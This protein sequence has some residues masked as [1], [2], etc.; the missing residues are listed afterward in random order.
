MTSG[1]IERGR[2]EHR[3]R[4]VSQEDSTAHLVAARHDPHRFGAFYRLEHRSL[5]R[6]VHRQV[7]CAELAADLTAE[8]FA[9]ALQWLR[10]FDPERGSAR[11]WL[12]G[13][14]RNEVRMWARKGRVSQSARQRLGITTPAFTETDEAMIDARH[15]ANGLL[16]QSRE[17]FEALGDLDRQVVQMRVIDELP[18]AVI[19]T[20]LD[21]SEV[22]ARVR[23]SRA[24]ARLRASLIG[25]IDASGAPIEQ[26]HRH[27]TDGQPGGVR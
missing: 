18:Y 21:C 7:L 6:H 13:I 17:A 8:S 1:A 16:V 15:D 4:A 26:L 19:A 25:S 5:F 20:A 14:A 12:Y 23:A 3:S 27:D 22:A 9:K 24:L 10:Q 11:Q 2:R